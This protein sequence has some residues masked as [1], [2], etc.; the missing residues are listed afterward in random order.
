LLELKIRT[1]KMVKVQVFGIEATIENLKWTSE[2]KEFEKLLNT[3]TKVSGSDSLSVAEPDL[4][5]AERIIELFKNE[6]T[7]IIETIENPRWKRFPG[8]IY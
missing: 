3:M 4:E 7:K 6:N 5:E 1:L 8:R 2:H